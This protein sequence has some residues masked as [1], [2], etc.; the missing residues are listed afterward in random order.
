[1]ILFTSS[2]TLEDPTLVDK[3]LS[4]IAMP[5]LKELFTSEQKNRTNNIVAHKSL[6][7][8]SKQIGIFVHTCEET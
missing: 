3:L 2:V 1:M 7:K 6:Q 4:Q 8:F 5:A